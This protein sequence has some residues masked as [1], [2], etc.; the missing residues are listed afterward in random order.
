[1]EGSWPDFQDCLFDR[2]QF[3]DDLEKFLFKEN[4]SNF[5]A[6]STDVTIPDHWV[7][8][9][10]TGDA[11]QH[12]WRLWVEDKLNYLPPHKRVGRQS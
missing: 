1:L 3:N 4:F 5:E 2:L 10:V 7:K 6:Q 12:E 11:L 9:Y 8:S